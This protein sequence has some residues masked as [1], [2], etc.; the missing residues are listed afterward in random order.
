VI[1]F[2]DVTWKCHICGE[3]RP[4]AALSVRSRQQ[5]LG[6]TI[7]MEVNVRYCND[8]PACIEASYTH[9]FFADRPEPVVLPPAVKK[10]WWKR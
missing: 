6:G 5:L 3:E 9:D 8:N 7:P 1:S 2:G 10:R 4:D